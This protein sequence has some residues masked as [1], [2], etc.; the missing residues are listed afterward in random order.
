MVTS[1]GGGVACGAAREREWCASAPSGDE[2][3]VVRAGLHRRRRRACIG[4][5]EGVRLRM[6]SSS[7]TAAG[8][9]G[10]GGAAPAIFAWRR[11]AVVSGGCAARR[12]RSGEQRRARA[13]ACVALRPIR[14]TRAGSTLLCGPRAADVRP[15][16]AGRPAAAAGL[17]AARRAPP[18]HA[19][20]RAR[21]SR[22][23]P[24]RSPS[25]RS[26]VAPAPPPPLPYARGGGGRRRRE[27]RVL[28]RG[29]V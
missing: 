25:P 21:R 23:I 11:A 18:A 9:A 15:P 10:D 19:T 8:S 7:S 28:R 26:H 16:R 12:S 17:R 1:S 29:A 20:A 27:R 13:A 5:P 3:N 2:S 4:Q 14:C 24:R 6:S 22:S